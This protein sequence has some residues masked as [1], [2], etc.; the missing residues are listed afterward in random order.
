VEQYQ[1]DLVAAAQKARNQMSGKLEELCSH[2]VPGDTQRNLQI[3]PTYSSDTF[4]HI[5]LPVWLLSYTYG[6][7]SWQVVI[8]GYDGKLAGE[9]PKSWVKISLLI[10]AIVIAI[11]IIVAVSGRR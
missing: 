5:L 6:G 8:N 4:K 1:I 7:R 9:Y 11:L 2:E 3:A 10:L